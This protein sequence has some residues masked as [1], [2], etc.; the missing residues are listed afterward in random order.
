MDQ[1]T[2]AHA[3]KLEVL[4]V[5]DDNKKEDSYRLVDCINSSNRT[6]Y[7]LATSIMLADALFG[8]ARQH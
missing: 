4:S 2:E 7:T 1:S 6:V 5:M 3:H 8:S